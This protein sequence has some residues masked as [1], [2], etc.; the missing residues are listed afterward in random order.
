MSICLL[1]SSEITAVGENRYDRNENRLY[2]GQRDDVRSRREFVHAPHPPGNAREQTDP[3]RRSIALLQGP[4]PPRL[5][6]TSKIGFVGRDKNIFAHDKY[7]EIKRLGTLLRTTTT[8]PDER[9][10]VLECK[11]HRSCVLASF[12]LV[13]M[14]V[15]G[16]CS[17]YGE[18]LVVPTRP[19]VISA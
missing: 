12:L 15:I 2:V 1:R 13:I 18:F 6:A 11:I 8:T 14:I 3:R 4:I 7:Q 17:W 16:L 19:K 10:T 9:C 5:A